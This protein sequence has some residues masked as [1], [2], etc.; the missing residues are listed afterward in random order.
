[1]LPRVAHVFG[2][3]VCNSSHDV[4]YIYELLRML[5]KSPDYCFGL[6][7]IMRH[8]VAHYPAMPHNARHGNPMGLFVDE[9][10]PDN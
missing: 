2:P 6:S 3:N 7:G 4:L 5:E 9:A 8:Y 10:L 1:M